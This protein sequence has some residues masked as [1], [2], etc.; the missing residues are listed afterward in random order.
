MARTYRRKNIEDALG[1]SWHRRGRKVAGFR[2][3]VDVN[4][5]FRETAQY[6]Y[7]SYAVCYRQMTPGEWFKAWYGL[8]G[9]SRHSNERTPGKWYRRQRCVQGRRRNK[10]ELQKYLHNP[11]YEPMCERKDLSHLWDWR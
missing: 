3:T 8:H 6:Y 2:T 4:Q 11:D 1:R 5:V 7:Y 10:R 9:E